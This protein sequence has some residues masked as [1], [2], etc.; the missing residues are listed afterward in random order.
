MKH[1]LQL[2]M[3]ITPHAPDVSIHPAFLK[4]VM[5]LWLL[6]KLL[7]LKSHPL[8]EK[9]LVTVLFMISMSIYLLLY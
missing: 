5:C 1:L 3:N 6:L 2:F 9:Y 4:H 7:V 8:Y